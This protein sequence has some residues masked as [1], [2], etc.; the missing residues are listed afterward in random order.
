[1]IV[2]YSMHVNID[3]LAVT[4]IMQKLYIVLSFKNSLIITII[5]T[6]IQS[7]KEE[8]Y[9]CKLPSHKIAVILLIL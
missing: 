7:Y 9:M 5:P 4:I 6:T 8:S 2:I 3:H 1:M